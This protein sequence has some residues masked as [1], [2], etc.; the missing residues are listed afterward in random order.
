[1]WHAWHDGKW[2]QISDGKASKKGKLARP[3]IRWED[4]G[5]KGGSV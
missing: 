3:S 4:N 5:L 1:M 2:I